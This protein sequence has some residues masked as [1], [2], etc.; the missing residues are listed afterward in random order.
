M[1]NAKPRS[2]RLV[3][4]PHVVNGLGETRGLPADVAVPPGT[5]EHSPPIHGW[6]RR[7]GWK[8]QSRQGRQ[9]FGARPTNGVVVFFRPDEVSSSGAPWLGTRGEMMANAGQALVGWDLPLPLTHWVT[10]T[11]LL[12]SHVPSLSRREPR[13]VR[14]HGVNVS[15]SEGSSTRKWR[16]SKTR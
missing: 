7:I 10:S 2:L 11:C 1:P 15:R 8:V 4:Q 16:R 5:T 3:S 13:I 9:K 6:E 12:Y 14:R